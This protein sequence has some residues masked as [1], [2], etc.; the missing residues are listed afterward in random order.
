ME[1]NVEIRNQIKI[2][3]KNKKKRYNLLNVCLKK[4]F[5]FINRENVVGGNILSKSKERHQIYK[6]NVILR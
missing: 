6:T 2:L 4:Y 3:V 5:D 1:K